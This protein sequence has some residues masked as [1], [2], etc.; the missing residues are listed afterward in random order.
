MHDEDR[1][2]ETK[3]ILDEASFSVRNGAKLALMGVEASVQQTTT[4]D[5]GVLHRVRTGPYGSPDEMNKVRNQL[6]Q[7]GIQATVVKVGNN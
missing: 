2:C 6:A 5:K 3:P 1:L 7:G 4:A